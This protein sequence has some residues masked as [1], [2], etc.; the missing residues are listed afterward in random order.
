M[1]AITL[2]DFVKGVFYP[3][4]SEKTATKVSKI[5]AV[6]FG[7]LSFGLIFVVENLGGVLQVHKKG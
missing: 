5:L 6:V 1:A 4:M 3:D 2:E 7:L